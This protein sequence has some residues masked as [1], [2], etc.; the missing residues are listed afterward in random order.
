MPASEAR[1]DTDRP[2]RYL[3]QFCRHANAI[4]SVE[5]QRLPMHGDGTEALQHVTVRAEWSDT[6]GTVSLDPWGHCR[7]EATETSLSIRLEACDDDTLRRIEDIVSTNIHRFSG[8]A[9]TPTWQH[10]GPP[11]A[12]LA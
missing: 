8:G 4:G 2:S 6:E 7:L 5:P 12:G 3:I 9:L 10:P 11:T 1:I